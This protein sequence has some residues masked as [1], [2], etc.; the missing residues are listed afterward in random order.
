[1]QEKFQN[2][3]KARELSTYNDFI[4]AIEDYKAVHNHLEAL[5]KEFAM[6]GQN[7]P[8]FDVQLATFREQYSSVIFDKWQSELDKN[9][10]ELSKKMNAVDIQFLKRWRLVVLQTLKKLMKARGLNM[11]L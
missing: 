2:A 6:L 9:L 11:M 1:M 8:T 7:T 5:Q 4:V 10:A 3:Y